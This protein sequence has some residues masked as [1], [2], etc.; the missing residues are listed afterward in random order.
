MAA[1]MILTM[2]MVFHCDKKFLNFCYFAIFIFLHAYQKYL[3][4]L[5]V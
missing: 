5:Q 2:H 1:I 4:I 3:F